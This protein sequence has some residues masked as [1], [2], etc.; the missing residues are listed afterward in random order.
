MQDRSPPIGKVLLQRTA[1]P[2]KSGQFQ[3]G[4]NAK[5]LSEWAILYRLLV[6]AGT[7]SWL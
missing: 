5:S 4:D 2:Y 1:G 3:L 6:P 7:D